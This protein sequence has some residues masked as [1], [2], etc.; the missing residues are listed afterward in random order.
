M[1]RRD[2]LAGGFVMGLAAA[3]LAVSGD[4][5]FGTLASPGAGMLPKLVL[6]LLLLFGAILILA[7]RTSPPLADL[8][9]SDLKHAA[10]VL[11]V[12]LVAVAVYTRL[13]FL[14]TMPLLLFALT[15]LAERQ[16]LLPSLAFSLLLPIATYVVFEWT[17]KTP[18]EHGII[19]GP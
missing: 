5:P 11:A 10:N 6:A 3:V 18:L 15:Y 14:L 17:L 7:A 4:L 2:H 12:T 16:R 8:D 1:L 13:G 19:L 9:T